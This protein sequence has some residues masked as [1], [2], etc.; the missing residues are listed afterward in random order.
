MLDE[1]VEFW[2]LETVLQKTGL[3]KSVLYQRIADRD[4]ESNPFPASR[5]YRHSR[6]AVFWRSDEVRAWQAVEA[7]MELVGA[8]TEI[9]SLLG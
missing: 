6:K 5:C 1:D 8:S 3:P 7:D 2:R 9:D 4:P